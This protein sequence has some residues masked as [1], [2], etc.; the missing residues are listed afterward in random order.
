MH[1]RLIFSANK[2]DVLI[3]IARSSLG[4]DVLDA[5]DALRVCDIAGKLCRRV[6]NLRYARPWQLQ[7]KFRTRHT[8]K[9]CALPARQPP[10]RKHANRDSEERILLE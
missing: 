2:G 3:T 9:L 7:K 8:A 1:T 10:E 4:A 6:G 5:I